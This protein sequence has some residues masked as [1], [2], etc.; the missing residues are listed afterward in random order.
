MF[1]NALELSNPKL[2]LITEIIVPVKKLSTF[3]S[4]GCMQS[5]NTALEGDAVGSRFGGRFAATL[6]AVS[7]SRCVSTVSNPGHGTRHI[8]RAEAVTAEGI[9]E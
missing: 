9:A 8:I 6:L 2:G 1:W 5:G 3:K 4:D 7:L